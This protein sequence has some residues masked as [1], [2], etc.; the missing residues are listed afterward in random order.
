MQ[1]EVEKS[2]LFH[3]QESLKLLDSRMQDLKLTSSK[4]CTASDIEKDAELCLEYNEKICTCLVILQSPET[5]AS[6]PT[7]ALTVGQIDVAR[8]LL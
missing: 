2:N 8:S 7:D 4:P 1:R 6:S 5:S 3:Y